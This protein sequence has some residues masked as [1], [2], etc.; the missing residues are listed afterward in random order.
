MLSPLSLIFSTLSIIFIFSLKSELNVICDLLFS[1]FEWSLLRLFSFLFSWESKKYKKFELIASNL[2][3]EVSN[4]S[5][6]KINT[7]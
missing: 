4:L 5:F 2:E 1:W 3:L 7:L 6:I